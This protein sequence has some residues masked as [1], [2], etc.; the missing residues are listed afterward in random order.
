M[1]FPGSSDGK[2]SVCNAEAPGSIP[3]SGRSPGEEN[4][5]LLQYSCLENPT[6]R[7]VWCTAVHAVA[8]SDTTERLTLSLFMSLTSSK[9]LYCYPKTPLCGILT[10]TQIGQVDG[11]GCMTASVL[12][13]SSIN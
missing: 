10:T 9:W 8:E 3:G 1:G 7:G 4:G 5:N 6:D 11:T 13:N 2:E 12:V